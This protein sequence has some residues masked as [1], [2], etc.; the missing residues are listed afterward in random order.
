MPDLIRHPVQFWIPASAGMTVLIYIVAGVIKQFLKKEQR[1]VVI[2]Q[3]NS[4]ILPATAS[5]LRYATRAFLTRLVR[6]S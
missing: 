3:M 1:G 6:R 5:P 4:L 2:V